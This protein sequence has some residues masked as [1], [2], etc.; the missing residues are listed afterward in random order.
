[1]C[2]MKAT[3]AGFSFVVKMPATIFASFVPISGLATSCFAK[4]E[5]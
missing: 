2:A 1:M 4:S 5:I 3:T